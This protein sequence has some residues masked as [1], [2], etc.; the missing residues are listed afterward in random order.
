MTDTAA[1]LASAL[2]ARTGKEAR[3]LLTVEGLPGADLA[4]PANP[5][6][7]DY[8]ARLAARPALARARAREQ[9]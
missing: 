6:L 9:G 5:V 7:A 2:E 3:T 1:I 4:L 8:T